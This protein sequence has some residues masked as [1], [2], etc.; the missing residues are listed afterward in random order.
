M[1]EDNFTDPTHV[2]EWAKKQCSHGI[3]NPKDC[4]ICSQEEKQRE[5]ADKH[6]TKEGEGDK[7]S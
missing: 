4:F 7:E 1:A 2:P 6:N 3:L 5:D